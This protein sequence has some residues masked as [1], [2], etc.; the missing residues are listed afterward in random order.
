[1]KRSDERPVAVTVG[2]LY[3]SA[4]AAGVAAAVVAAPTQVELVAAQRGGVIATAGLVAVMAVCVAGIAAMLYPLLLADAGTTVRRGL[5]TWFLGSRLTEGALF[6]V[7]A[8]V[9]LALLAV[10]Q[11][12]RSAADGPVGT[13]LRVLFDYA[14]VAGQTVFSVGAAAMCW[15][16]A[17]VRPDT[18][19][20]RDLGTR[21]RTAD[22]DGRTAA[23]DHERPVG[24][25][26]PGAL[27]PDG[28]AGDGAGGLADHP[29]LPARRANRRPAVGRLLH[30]RS[31]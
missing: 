1:M 30:S 13:G 10:G 8:V 31:F 14:L 29:G 20:A 11:G 6:L 2:V 16:A 4:T 12:P 21:G 24:P 15:L 25:A 28:P 23:A 7:G 3:V 5:A 27:R 17:G 19:V 9:L 22:A 26:R 18:A